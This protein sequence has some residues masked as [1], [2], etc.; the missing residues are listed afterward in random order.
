MSYDPKAVKISKSI[1]RV[2][3]RIV[4]NRLRNQFIRGYVAVEEEAQRN[5]SSRNRREKPD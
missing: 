3:A 2:A 4:D 5:R 1:K